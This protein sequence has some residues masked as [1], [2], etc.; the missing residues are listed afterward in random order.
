MPKTKLKRG[1]AVRSNRIVK[2]RGDDSGYTCACERTHKYPAYVYAHWND[3]LTHTCECG[4]TATIQNGVA[5]GKHSN[6]KRSDGT[7]GSTP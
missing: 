4:R 2:M 5:V 3:E 7:K 6:T 1:A